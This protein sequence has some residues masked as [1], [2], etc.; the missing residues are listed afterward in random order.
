[1]WIRLPESSTFLLLGVG[2]IGIGITRLR[3]RKS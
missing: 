1:M 2:L 3:Q